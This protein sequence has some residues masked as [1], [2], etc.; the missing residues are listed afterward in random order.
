MVNP[1]EAVYK[2]YSER[3]KIETVMRYY[4]SACEFDETRVQDDYSV[5]GSEFIDFLST[6]LTFRL[7]NEFE[8]HNLLDTMTYKRIMSILQRAKKSQTEDGNWQLIKINPLYEVMLQTL[9]L[10]PK[11]EEPPK[12]KRGRP[13]KF[14]V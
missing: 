10:L 5:I 13:G 6:L 11:P 14:R 9:G 7:L 4:K 2:S 8:K 1:S 12:K 3:W